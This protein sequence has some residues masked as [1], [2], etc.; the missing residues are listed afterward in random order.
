MTW[1]FCIVALSRVPL[2]DTKARYIEE[3]R[4]GLLTVDVSE[5]ATSDED[6]EVI[7]A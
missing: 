7:N 2:S 4:Q 6:K 1:P 3:G 5:A